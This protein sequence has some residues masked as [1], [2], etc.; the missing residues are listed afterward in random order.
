MRDQDKVQ[1]KEFL[2]DQ[3]GNASGQ[4]LMPE[5][6]LN[7]AAQQAG[8]DKVW[9]AFVAH[10]TAKRKEPRSKLRC[11]FGGTPTDEPAVI[12]GRAGARPSSG[13]QVYRGIPILQRSDAE[14]L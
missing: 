10:F 2:L 9:A 6:T 1:R 8:R 12:R 5:S 4:P 7:E 11:I 13:T 3:M 14:S